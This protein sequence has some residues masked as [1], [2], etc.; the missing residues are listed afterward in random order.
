MLSTLH[1]ENIAII[2][3]L[4]VEFGSGFIVLTGETGAG[5]SIIID[6]IQLLLGNKASKDLVRTG[7]AFGVVN[8]CFHGLSE[9]AL[10]IL[11]ANGLDADEDGNVTVYRKIGADGRNSSRING[12][13][14]TVSLLR[15]LGEHLINIHGQH[16]GVL[17]LDD[18]RHLS[19]LDEFADI[20]TSDYEVAYKR[21][22]EL[23]K[24]LNDMQAAEANKA[25]R[26]AEL[27]DCVNRLDR[28]DLKL[29][30]Y[31]DLMNKRKNLMLNAEIIEALHGAS[32]ALYDG[33]EPAAQLAKTALDAILPVEKNIP[34]GGEVVR[35]LTQVSAELD[36]LGAELGKLFNDYAENQMEPQEIETRLDALEAIRKEFGPSDEEVLK[37]QERFRAELAEL[38]T[39]EDHIRE[40]EQQFTE[41]R[42][43]LDQCAGQ[44]TDARKAAAAAMEKRLREE[45]Q[46][47][48]MPKV[49]FVVRVADRLN[50]RGGL[51]YRN[52]GKDDVEF[53]L[54]T[55][56]G[57]E[58][59]PL[60]KIASG[61][62][63]SRI[64][65]SI[66]SVL[67][68]DIDT[69]I[70]DEVDTG[71]SGATADKIGKKLRLSAD[72]RQVFCITHLA[73]IAARADYHYKVKKMSRGDRVCSQIDLL[74]TDERIKEV[75][76]IMGGEVLT[77]QLLLTAKEII[78]NTKN[79]D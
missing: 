7:E 26:Q 41:A 72:G 31:D 3:Y 47:L 42:V 37:N 19:Y 70:Y 79:N 46:Y 66:K 67:N 22:K 15:Q 57:E 40:L 50:D 68:R 18:R 28:C 56:T 33:E 29:G 16:D 11:R 60:A 6:S 36:D 12:V 10:E 48:D 4:D 76:R 21:V 30:E 73:Q 49:R 38:E 13:S 62:E 63:L 27:T 58:P 44:L 43:L 25:T 20:S 5:K 35:R 32:T 9:E 2:D 39:S 23:R 53:Y 45:L 74:S 14:V 64:M 24:Q 54:S 8:A 71:V 1:I 78:E 34:N 69:V 59:R 65:L 52:D 17:L 51:R 55:N 77:D 75:A 61:G